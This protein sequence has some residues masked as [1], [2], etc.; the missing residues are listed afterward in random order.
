[1]RAEVEKALSLAA[2]RHFSETKCFIEFKNE[3]VILYMGKEP[4]EFNNLSDMHEFLAAKHKRFHVYTNELDLILKLYY[5]YDRKK[6]KIE[7]LVNGKKIY[8]LNVL[9]VV[10][11][12]DMKYR[13]G[14]NNFSAAAAVE[15]IGKDENHIKSSFTSNLGRL[16]DAESMREKFKPIPKSLRLKMMEESSSGAIILANIGKEFTNVHCYDVC[17]AYIGCLLE[18]NMPS[19]FLKTSQMIRGQQYFGKVIIKGLKAK[20]PQ[21]LTLY[22]SKKKEGKNISLVGHRII[23]AEEYRFYCFL[24]EKWIIDQYYT[25]DSFEVDYDQ[26]WLIKFEKLPL[27]TI[28]AIRRLYDNKLNAKGQIDYDAYK[29]IVN[30]IYGFF[31]TKVERE[32]ESVARD[33]KIP[34]Q[35]GLW[36][37]H[38]Q[39]LFM[40]SLIAAVGLNHVVSAHTDGVK[41][42]CD[43]DEIVNKINQARGEIYKDVGQ[44]K[45][46][47]TLDRCFYF[48]NTVGKYQIGDKIG[49]KHGGVPLADVEEFLEGKTYDEINDSE[50][51][52]RTIGREIVCEENR[53]YIIKHKQR[54]SF[55]VVA[56]ANTQEEF[57][58][59]MEKS[60]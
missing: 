43:A 21:M 10:S 14:S 23:A 13:Y 28:K 48:S 26:L 1:M 36:I 11:Y 30:R 57:C 19:R 60:V 53:T 52:L 54:T 59:E 4:F 9:N 47:D 50:E 37:I 39:R 56:D 32:G 35:I 55:L 8:G 49:M 33:Y 51:F 42:D 27:S 46:E 34:Y 29:Q 31:L 45:K 18:G 25:Y 5:K 40:T 38:R 44:W 17:S 2:P 41:F 20:N 12:K 6:Y 15:I 58:N 16:I 22:V 24:N 7:P 3:K